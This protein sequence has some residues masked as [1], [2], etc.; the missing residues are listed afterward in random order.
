MSAP[1]ADRP[2]R[3]DA[4]QNRQRLLDAAADVF[5]EHGLEA[6][7]EEIART[8]GV[9]M[10][11]LYRRFPTKDALI[12]ALV[13]DVLT[14]MLKIA[15]EGT[16]RPDGTGLEYF[17]EGASAYQAAHR[18]CLPR[19][20][21]DGIE[22]D[23]VQE[24]RRLIDAMLTQAKRHGRIRGDITNTDVT[25]ALWA[26]RGII[27]TTQGLAPEAWQRHLDIYIAGLRPA[28]DPLPD[29]ELSRE[30]LDELITERLA[31][32]SV[33]G[34]RNRFQGP[35][36]RGR[37]RRTA[38]PRRGRPTRSAPTSWPPGHRPPR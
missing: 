8:A 1:A 17:L 38:C 12:S 20:W 30:K 27:E 25:I 15:Q 18:G 21:N 35:A 24:I 29:R 34:A 19:L 14:T 23:L 32:A 11:T 16:E 4:E 36:G 13:H 26:I 5:A 7:V 2:L 37:P 22:H 9:G 3:R 6:S 33:S 31:W 10:G 28:A